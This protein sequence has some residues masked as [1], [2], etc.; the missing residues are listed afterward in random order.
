M[1]TRCSLQLGHYKVSLGQNP[2]R[3]RQAYLLDEQ[4]APRS[5]GSIDA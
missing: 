5:Y 3:T 2:W 4:T 1:L